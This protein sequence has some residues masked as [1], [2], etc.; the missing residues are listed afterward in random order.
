M[1]FRSD[2]CI[3]YCVHYTCIQHKIQPLSNLNRITPPVQS[4][5]VTKRLIVSH[6]FL[7]WRQKIAISEVQS[8]LSFPQVQCHKLNFQSHNCPPQWEQFQPHFT[9]QNHSVHQKLYL[10]TE[11]LAKTCRVQFCTCSTSHW[12][13]LKVHHTLWYGERTVVCPPHECLAFIQ[14]LQLHSITR[15]INC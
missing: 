1:G 4:T 3:Q 13:R 14:W 5:Q 11:W 8:I 9:Q 15:D 2:T 10:G 6:K 12:G 7:D